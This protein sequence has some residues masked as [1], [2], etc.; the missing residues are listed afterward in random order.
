MGRARTTDLTLAAGRYT[1][2]EELGRGGMAVVHLAR[3]RELE[4]PVA[5]KILDESLAADEAFV[6]RFRR[7]ATT[8]AR[9]AHPNVVQIYDFGEEDE[10]L[11]IVMEFVD[12]VA[13]DDL[14]RRDGPLPLARVLDL[15]GQSCRGLQYAHE[16]GVVHRDVKPANLLLRRDGILK[17]ADFG[18]ARAGGEATQLTS[19][20][21]VLG[22]ASYL[23]P[24]QAAGKPVTSRADLYALGA[25][26]YELLTGTPPRKI[27]TLAQLAGIAE[28][29]IEPIRE[30]A[31]DAPEH[32]EATI[33]RCLARNPDYRPASAADLAA[34]LAGEPVPATRVL[35][36]PTAA[37]RVLAARR[38]AWATR[39]TLVAA[40]IVFL[41]LLAVAI[42]VVVAGKGRSEGV[43]Q[44]RTVP[45]LE[46][47]PAASDPARQAR[48]LADWLRE[49]AG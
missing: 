40:L 25:V 33:M 34:S 3:D 16:Q 42:G 46:P 41:A 7:E 18:I 31:P 36:P 37:T 13:L 45:R 48:N 43:P 14:V 26:L 11:H 6:R 49:N 20:G 29:P 12:G 22:T 4:W 17:I 35:G 21:T 44:D 1:L 47:V 32:V 19:A 30:R 23:A 27:E 8:A 10:R 24:E 15:A 28:E 38:R 39:R 9:L 5:V 2:D